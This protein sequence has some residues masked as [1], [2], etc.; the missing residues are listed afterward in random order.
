MRQTFL[1]LPI[2][3]VLAVSGCTSLPGNFCI[4]GLTCGATNEE[5]NDVIV[6][7]SLQAFPSEVTD[8]GTIKLSAIVSNVASINAEQKIVDVTVELYDYCPGIF[9]IISGKSIIPI[10]LL[11]GEKKQLEWTLQ[12]ADSKTIPVKTECTL[13]VRAKYR[14]ST[15]SITTL[16][17]IDNKEMQ[18]MLADGTY[19]A[20]G[21]YQSVG[22]GPIKP[23]I[24]IEDEQPI[25]V[26]NGKPVNI[27]FSIQLVNRGKGFLSGTDYSIE[28]NKFK[29]ESVERTSDLKSA[30][31][32]CKSQYLNINNNQIKFIKGESAIIPCSVSISNIGNVPIETTK[33]VKASI[34]DY[35]YE[36]RQ[37][38]TVKVNPRF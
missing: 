3:I 11:R 19:E 7:E 13:K 26:E 10:R 14:Y 36:F 4:P 1:A 21:S 2:I 23:Y 31:D 24:N 6:I 12:A 38:I 5:T 22:Y 18:R 28:G 20:V 34:E 37:E 25:P 8:S 16:H 27:A 35:D 29:I 32:A 9:K 33:T 17:L 15:T 30:L